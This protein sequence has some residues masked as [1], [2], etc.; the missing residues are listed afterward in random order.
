MLVLSRRSGESIRI[1]PDV[2]VN[3]LEVEGNRVKLGIV[4]PSEISIWRTELVADGDPLPV[5]RLCAL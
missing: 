4:A 3:V 1:G 2:L 5:R